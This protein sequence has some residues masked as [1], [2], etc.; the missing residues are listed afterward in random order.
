MFLYCNVVDSTSYYVK[1]YIRLGTLTEC[2]KFRLTN[3]SR[4]KVKV[5]VVSSY[6]MGYTVYT[7]RQKLFWQ[8]LTHLNFLLASY[9]F[10]TV[11]YKLPYCHR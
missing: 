5:G 10:A 7:F 2:A 1:R 6:V 9:S 3:L 11:N 8:Q 4:S